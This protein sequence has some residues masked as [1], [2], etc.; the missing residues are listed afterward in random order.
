MTDASLPDL[1][2][3]AIGA[4][5]RAGAFSPLEVTRA[6]LE[7]IAKTDP[8]IHAWVEVA[9][10]EALAA[11]AKAE[12]EIA[13]NIDRGPLHGVPIGVKDIID[14]AGMPTRCGSAARDDAPP[15]VG[16]ARVVAALRNAGAIVLGKTVTQEFA[17]G[18]LSPPARNPWDPRRSPGGSS[19]GSA[20]AVAVGAC[21]AALGSDTGGSIRIPA[22]ACGV[23]GF[24]PTFFEIDLRGVYPLSWS[25]D[26]VGPLARTVPDAETMLHALLGTEPSAGD[27][28]ERFDNESLRGTRIGVSRPFF[29]DWLQP[30]VAASVDAALDALGS[31]GATIVES[32]WREGAAARACAFVINR[33]ETAAVHERV[34]LAEPDRFQRYGPELRLRIAAGRQLPVSLYV[35]AVRARAV[36]RDSISRL[37]S[38]YH[39]DVLVA[40]ALPTTAVTAEAPAIAGTGRDESVGAGWT[41]LTM[42]FNATGQPVLTVPSGLDR[43]GLPVGI[44]IAGRPGDEAAIFQIGRAFEMMRGPLHP[45]LL[46]DLDRSVDAAAR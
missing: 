36:I 3:A 44:Q 27:F 22:A 14:V 43:Q 5:Y 34:A 33:V 24:K 32:P 10:E 15:A 11:A 23:V 17:A 12:Q 8:L 35:Q 30:D 18:V 29:F 40:P 16:D 39:L 42:P 38:E 9:T 26:T 6:V 37:F 45:P 20:A 41:R 25:L 21:F 2:I 7:R 4:G 31:L 1:G 13:S 46:P 28:Q 19:G